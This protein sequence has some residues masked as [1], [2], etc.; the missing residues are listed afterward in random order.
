MIGQISHSSTNV[1]KPMKKNQRHKQKAQKIK[2]AGGV[3]LVVDDKDKLAGDVDLAV[4]GANKVA[5]D[6]D[7]AG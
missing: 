5:S 3:D 6:R 2:Y 4:E 1:I 7:L